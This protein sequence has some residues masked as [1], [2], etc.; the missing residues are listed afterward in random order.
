MHRIVLLRY[1]TN[2]YNNVKRESIEYTQD[3]KIA[4]HLCR[5]CSSVSE[6]SPLALAPPLLSI[7]QV[8]SIR[9]KVW[10][11]N[12][13]RIRDASTSAKYHFIV[14]IKKCSPSL[15][16]GA[17]T[18]FLSRNSHDFDNS[19]M[20]IWRKVRF[21]KCE[22]CEKLRFQKCKFLWKM[23]LWKCEFCEK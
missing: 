17:K 14:F 9:V 23:R 5:N 13:I 7:A 3:F 19:K 10:W 11:D 1:S 6:E 21:Q 15:H 16:T 4:L 8:F 2:V 22:F 12:P 18:H 20:W